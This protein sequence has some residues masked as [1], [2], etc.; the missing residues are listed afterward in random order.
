M[1]KGYNSAMHSLTSCPIH[2][3]LLL[4]AALAAFVLS[5]VK[6]ATSTDDSE[7]A[8]PYD[9]SEFPQWTKD[10]RRLEIVSLGSVPFV[11]FAVATTFSSY[12]YFSGES[13]QFI[14]PFARSSYSEKEQMQIFFFSIGTGVFIG[15]TDLTINIIKRR[16]ER[17]RAMRIKAA[18]DQIIVV[19]FK[20]AWNR[21]S[22]ANQPPLGASGQGNPPP[23]GDFAEG[24]DPQEHRPPPP[25]G[26]STEDTPPQSSADSQ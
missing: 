11:M 7:T 17:K 6:A 4:T 12:L 24:S 19:P 21:P 23:Q 9:L 5:P 15:L 1:V 26:Q 8:E 18:E 3:L 16:G 25:D 13:Q 22:G 14:N 2:K 10:L 20:D